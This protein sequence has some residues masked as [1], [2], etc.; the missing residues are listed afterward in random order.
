MASNFR[1]LYT[2]SRINQ[3]LKHFA[4]EEKHCCLAAVVFKRV[5][6]SGSGTTL[7]PLLLVPVT[8]ACVP[9]RGVEPAAQQ[10]IREFLW[11]FPAAWVGFKCQ[12]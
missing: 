8:S 5:E 2:H 1:S 4:L 3:F 6:E 11:F 9:W 12:D 10:F 7:G